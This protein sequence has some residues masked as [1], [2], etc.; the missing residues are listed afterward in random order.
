[1]IHWQKSTTKIIEVSPSQT[2]HILQSARYEDQR[3]LDEGWVRQYALA[4]AQ[5]RFR[6]CSLISYAL[7]NGKRF[8]VNGQ[9]TLEAIHLSGKSYPIREE[10]FPVDTMEDVA[11]L[12]GT[13]DQHR[14]RSNSQ[15]Y[16]AYRLDEQANMG[17]THVSLLGSAMPLVM[18]G[19]TPWP[20]QARGF[21]VFMRDQWIKS[22]CITA[23]AGEAR[24]YFEVIHNCPREI[25]QGL[26]RASVMAVAVVTIRHTGTD[27]EEFWHEVAMGDGLKQGDL[28]LTLHMFL[29]KHSAKEFDAHVYARYVASAWNN[30]C[31]GRSLRQLNI[32]E[33]TWDKPIRIA[34]TPHDGERVMRYLTQEGRA[35]AQ[36]EEYQAGGPEQPQATSAA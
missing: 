17:K 26:R 15:I 11:Q 16:K 10:V 6:P 33:T 35:L 29:R 27:A 9:H 19:F 25:S 14:R 32:H 2:L 5:E 36:P 28:R 1:M 12:Y 8:L 20:T 24:T 31:D 21:G 23:W 4:M 7:F 22:Q 18:S 30:F 3:T 34:E 13:F